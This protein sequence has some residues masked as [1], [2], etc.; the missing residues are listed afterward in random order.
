MKIEINNGT[1]HYRIVFIPTLEY[2]Y[3]WGDKYLNIYDFPAG[4]PT[5]LIVG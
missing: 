4:K 2:E 3:D 1:D 5:I